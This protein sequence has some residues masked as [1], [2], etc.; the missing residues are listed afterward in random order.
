ML[1]HSWPRPYQ[2]V[3]ELTLASTLVY[4]R[5]RRKFCISVDLLFNLGYVAL[6][7]VADFAD[8][9]NMAGRYVD[10]MLLFLELVAYLLAYTDTDQ[11]AVCQTPLI[12]HPTVPWQ[13]LLTSTTKFFR[14]SEH[15]NMI[16]VLPNNS[17]V[18]GSHIQVCIGNST[19]SIA[20]GIWWRFSFV[21]CC[22]LHVILAVNFCI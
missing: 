14:G 12:Q 5:K 11:C 4:S 1:H 16:R 21:T 3:T 15:R 8:W 6:G 22:F 17:F 20:H 19:H 7:Y 10:Q 9:M 2:V 18:P 13:H